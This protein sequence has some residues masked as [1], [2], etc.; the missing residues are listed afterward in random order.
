VL[1]PYL[2]GVATLWESAGM[3]ALASLLLAACD[4]SLTWTNLKASVFLTARTTAR[5]IWLVTASA[6]FMAVFSYV[7][8]QIAL[9]SFL[10]EFDLTPAVF[11][12]LV[13]LFI[14]AL[15]WPLDWPEIVI[16][17]VPFLLPLLD[18]M[19]IDPLF[20][21]VLLALNIQTSFLSPPVAAAPQILTRIVTPRIGLDQIYLGAMPF[22]WIILLEMALLYLW[23][24]IA[25][26]LPGLLAR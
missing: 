11:L 6:V 19:G 12:I 9:D 16:V 1:G 26:W 5:L 21:G 8:G 17:V 14:F 23:P 22:V 7:G 15:G 2:A 25:L 13:Q 20:F 4:R 10:F 3:A 24:E 18:S